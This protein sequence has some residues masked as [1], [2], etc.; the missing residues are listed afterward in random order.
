[1][2]IALK[3]WHFYILSLSALNLLILAT[4]VLS[5]Y[6][7]PVGH[8]LFSAF[9]LTCHQ[10]ASRSYCFYPADNS[11]GDCP[12]LYARAPAL[13][14]EKGPAYEFPVC[15]RDIAIYAG[16]LI[17][18][19]AVYFTKWK[20]A[21]QT[22]NPLIFVLALIPIA[23]D[24]GTQLL[25]WRESTNMLRLITGFLAGLAFSFYFVP[26]LNAVFLKKEGK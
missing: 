25:G 26:M 23:I 13:P 11:V 8:F 20:D 4:P 14:S 9:S 21:R 22:P 5:I 19:I 6:A 16:A 12:P 3:P 17:S 2:S 24:G 18:G 1:M 10:L 15:A 7:E